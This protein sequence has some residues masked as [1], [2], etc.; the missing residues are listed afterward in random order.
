MKFRYCWL[1]AAVA[2]GSGCGKDE[3]DEAARLT[4]VLTEK[5]ANFASANALEKTFIGS[6][7]AWC[8]GITANGGGKGAVLDENAAVAAELAKNSV[9]VGAELSQ[10]RQAVDDLSLK[11]EFTQGVRATLATQLTKR[12]RYLQDMRALLDQAGPEFLTYHQ[13]KTYKGDLFPGGLGK[14]E[15]MLDSYAIPN[16]DVGAA[17]GALKSKYN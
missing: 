14:L 5:Q 15:S 7:R 13:S 3:R 16:D 17:L 11:E 9:A 12:Q 8:G 4:K 10:V 2:L 6:A 1:V